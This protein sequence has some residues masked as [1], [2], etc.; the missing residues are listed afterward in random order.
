MNH[1]EQ[2]QLERRGE[3]AENV[4]SWYFRLN[5]F[6][7]IPSFIIH[8]NE[9]RRHPRTEA[10]LLGVR[11]PHSIERIAG[12]RMTDDASITGLAKPSQILLILVEIKN[13]V[14]GI[15]GPWTEEHSGNM[16][17][18]IGR[19]GFAKEEEIES[20]AQTMYKQLRWEDSGTVL[21]YVTVGRRPNRDLQRAYPCLKQVTFR[22]I[23]TFLFERFTSF[24]Q[25]L[26]TGN[27][28]HSQWPDF[29]KQYGQ[30]VSSIRRLREESETAL[31]RY[32]EEGRCL[33]LQRR[34]GQH[35][36]D[37]PAAPPLPF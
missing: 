10:D 16:Q 11:F 37:H 17:R 25:K 24:P 6:L 14:C 33:P 29:G 7:S 32:I 4:A 3:R 28:V 20:I 31:L 35:G 12:I 27:R 22:E 30:W 8:P 5:G 36:E 19:L 1:H 34:R 2:R 21:Q 23:S 15:N 9:C 26:P 18:V 13:D